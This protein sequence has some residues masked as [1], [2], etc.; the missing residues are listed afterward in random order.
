MAA[1]RSGSYSI[2]FFYA[3]HDIVIVL[4]AQRYAFFSFFAN[5]G[6]IVIE[7]A[8]VSYAVST[9]SDGELACCRS[10]A[11]AVGTDCHLVDIKAMGNASAAVI[12]KIPNDRSRD[13]HVAAPVLAC[14]PHRASRQVI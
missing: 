12:R 13:K 8:A 11:A 3:L 14:A 10:F 5:V 7:K 4:D 2:K 9:W 1:R 6:H